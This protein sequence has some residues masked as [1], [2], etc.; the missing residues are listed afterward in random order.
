MSQ[1]E[2]IEQDVRKKADEID[3]YRK[4]I[5]QI[6]FEIGEVDRKGS[7]ENERRLKDMLEDT[8]R[9]LKK[10]RQEVEDLITR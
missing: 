7:L 3:N 5:E 2:Q 6:E 9:E 10:S 1:R 8:T 4:Q